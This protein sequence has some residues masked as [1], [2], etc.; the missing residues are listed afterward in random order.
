MEHLRHLSDIMEATSIKLHLWLY[1]LFV[2]S[3]VDTPGAKRVPAKLL[4][5]LT[6]PIFMYSLLTTGVNAGYASSCR[7]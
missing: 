1:L 2:R 5:R 3:P 7:Q 4:L 6:S